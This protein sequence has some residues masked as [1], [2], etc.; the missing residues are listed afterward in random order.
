MT[1]PSRLLRRQIGRTGRELFRP[2][3][4]HLP[5]G[6]FSGHVAVIHAEMTAVEV[7]EISWI[8]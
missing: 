7:G 1:R 5:A 8:I 4:N 6:G 2:A 3:A